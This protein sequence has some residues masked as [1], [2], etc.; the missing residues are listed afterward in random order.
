MCEYR[1]NCKNLKFM[2]FA[3]CSGGFRGGH[4]YSPNF[5]QFHAVFCKIWQNHMLAP[6]PPRAGA[7]SYGKSWI[8]PWNDW[9]SGVHCESLKRCACVCVSVCGCVAWNCSEMLH[10]II[11]SQGFTAADPA[12]GYGVGARNKK[13]IRL[14]LAAIFITDCNEVG[15]RLCFYRHL[16]FC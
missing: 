15:P 3:E 5:S 4:P 10:Q 2:L 9:F 14:P 7:P 11:R 16:W 12:A 1:S 8:R 13:S 6:P